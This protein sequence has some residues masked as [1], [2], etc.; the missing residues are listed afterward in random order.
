MT[1]YNETIKNRNY[2]VDLLRIIAMI[3]VTTHHYLGHG[4]VLDTVNVFSLNWYVVWFMRAVCYI[5]VT[6]FFIISAYYLSIKSIRLNSIIRLWLE[7]WFYSVACYAVMCIIKVE[8][9][10]AISLVKTMFPIMFRQYGFFNSYLLMTL[11]SPFLNIAINAFQ[12]KTHFILIIMLTVMCCVIPYISFVD[13]FNM[14]YGEGTL[15]ILLL[16]FS[17]AYLQK[18]DILRD[19]ICYP[20]LFGFLF[21]FVQYM[22]KIF[23]SA[24]TQILFGVVKY[25]GAFFGETPLLCFLASILTFIGFKNMGIKM[26]SKWVNKLVR[27][28]APLVFAVYLIQESN[29]VKNEL[30]HF[31]NSSQYANSSL[32]TL[33]LDYI[34]TVM[35]IFVVA[36]FIEKNSF[37]SGK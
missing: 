29:N 31:V 30:W 3:M 7:V 14:S 10:K 33:L 12:K 23:I 17:A 2:G 37:E 28:I 27:S 22:T 4:G 21:C 15:W 13:A 25:S 34:I 32:G 18:Y 35:M 5:S 26:N 6:V 8:E 9:F 11:L 20:L 1:Q 16:Y 19:K 24:G 36:V